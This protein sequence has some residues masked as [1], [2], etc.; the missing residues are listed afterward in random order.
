MIVIDN[1]RTVMQLCQAGE[2][3][4]PHLS[5]WLAVS[6]HAF[7]T[8]RAESLN[9]AFGLR[10]ARGGIPWRMEANI[11]VRDRALRGLATAHFSGLSLSARAARIHELSC[12][13][14][15]ASW[16][17]DRERE[18]MPPSY[19][20]TPMAGL[21]QAFKSGAAMPLCQRQLQKILA[22]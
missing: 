5:D 16:R 17:F 20:G 3:L 9:D 12:R 6:L 7:L 4:P 13:Y 10:N 8:N 14:A 18:A 22:V 15:A 11:R 21:W 2:T 1:M 19:S